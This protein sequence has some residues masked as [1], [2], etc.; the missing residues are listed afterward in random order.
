[1]IYCCRECKKE[2]E[3][4]HSASQYPKDF[5]SYGCYEKWLR[6]NRTPNCEC[7]VCGK[8]MYLKPSRIKRAKNGVTCSKECANKLKA[9]YMKGELNHQYGLKGDKNASFKGIEI[10]EKNNNLVE[11]LVYIPDHPY[12]NKNGRVTKHRLL[13]EQNYKNFDEKYF[14]EINGFIVLKRD[15]YVHHI[16]GN[17]SNNDLSNLQI[18]TRSEHTSIHNKEREIIRDNLGRITGV[19]K[20]EELL[21]TPEVVNQQPSQ[22]LTKLEGSET[23]D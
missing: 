7:A 10:T 20:R 9:T 21:E 4:N 3:D 1:M 14:E 8:K 2:F 6:S 13:V 23:N 16:D 22:P 19:V 17:H 18:V 5:C 15:Y 12:A 11:I